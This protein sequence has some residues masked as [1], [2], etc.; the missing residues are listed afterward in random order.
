MSRR[1]S[2]AAGGGVS[3]FPFLSILACLIG[4]LTLLIKIIGDMKTLEHHQRDKGE[5]ARAE[6]MVEFQ[7]Q[8]KTLRQESATL[9]QSLAQRDS[10]LTEMTDL[11]DRVIVLR[12]KLADETAKS[13]NQDDAAM[14]KQL[15]RMLAQIAALKAERPALE[16]QLADLRAELEK[17]K[18]KPTDKP[19]PVVIQPGGTGLYR[20]AKV[21][22]VECNASGLALLE[23]NGKKTPVSL[24]TIATDPN[25]STLLKQAKA[26]P[27]GYV[28]FLIRTTGHQAWSH[29]A[30]YAEQQY[31]VV[32]GKLPIPSDG[33]IDLARF[34]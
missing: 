9:K 5:L 24:A 11:E 26:H 1:E 12:K 13:A 32:T 4:I 3:L 20:N 2:N 21:F 10:S 31:Q 25:F 6:R 30:G 23:L 15:E 29:A 8:L 17:R 18:L 16:K 27:N 33:E 22:F 7:Q 19:P 14:Q 28:L 34:K